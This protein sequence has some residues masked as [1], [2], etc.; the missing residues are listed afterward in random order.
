MR[1]TLNPEDYEWK[2]TDLGNGKFK[3][4]REKTEIQKINIKNIRDYYYFKRIKGK[5][6]K[7]MITIASK[8]QKN[9]K[10]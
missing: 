9:E 6:I 2:I 3:I 7:I 5:R 10:S 8:N 1:I 4:H